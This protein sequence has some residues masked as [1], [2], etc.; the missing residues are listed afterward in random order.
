MG[1]RIE[2]GDK[3]ERVKV[4]HLCP[5][6]CGPMDCSSPG[7]SVHGILQTRVLEWVSIRSDD[8]EVLY[9]K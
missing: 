6:L 4:A 7:S 5:I 9:I 1:T 3:C 8:T 2:P